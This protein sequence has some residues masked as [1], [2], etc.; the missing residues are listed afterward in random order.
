MAKLSEI[1]TMEKERADDSAL[2]VIHLYQEGSFLRAYEWSAWLCCRYLNDFKVTKRQIKGTD[3]CMTFIGFPQTSL[4][5]YS[6]EGREIVSVDDKRIDVVLSDSV[7]RETLCQDDFD[8]WKQS[9]PFAEPKKKPVQQ[10]LSIGG[11]QLPETTLS[12]T[13][14][15]QKILA[16]PIERMSPLDCM[17]FMAEIKTQIAMLF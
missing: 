8:N 9:V 4:E 15:M 11:I 3:D 16:F 10:M 1:L 13:G 2:H 12:M 14:I 6:S 7:V 5:K 17:N